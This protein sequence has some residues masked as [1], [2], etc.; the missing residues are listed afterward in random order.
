MM[1]AA[2]VTLMLLL[3]MEVLVALTRV[4]ITQGSRFF[5]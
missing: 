1:M 2:T 3:V 4:I 5:D